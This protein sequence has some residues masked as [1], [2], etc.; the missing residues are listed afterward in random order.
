MAGA[1][2]GRAVTMA[3]MGQR[4]GLLQRLAAPFRE[5]GWLAGLLYLIDRG[6]QRL[7]PRLRLFAYE[8]MAQPIPDTP[9]LP[10]SLSKNLSFRE[11]GR[12][13]PEVE[14]MP[15]RPEIKRTRFDQGAVCLGAYRKGELIG[16]IWLCFNAYD[17]DEV[18]C[19]YRLGEP[20]SSVF[21]FDLYVLPEHRLGIGF[22]AVW[23]GA[24]AY[25]REHGIRYSFS[26]LTRSNIAS[27]RSHAHFGWLCVGRAAFLQAGS[28]ELMLATLS[29]YVSVSI[30]PRRRALLTLRAPNA[31]GA[32]HASP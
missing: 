21:D 22:A 9:L 14:R 13:D 3:P 12:G 18:R 20:Q 25:L 16:Y 11:I 32:S 29:P 8:F 10:S 24:N 23:H 5:L 17:E 26:R 27:R 30:G 28:V 1:G 7:S 2:G 15:A 6:L 4:V 19:T 31:T